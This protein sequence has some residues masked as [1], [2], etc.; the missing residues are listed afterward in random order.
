MDTDQGFQRRVTGV[1]GAMLMD[2]GFFLGAFYLASCIR[3]ATFGPSAFVLY[4]PGLIAGAVTLVFASFV[5]GLYS[6]DQLW[7]Q[8]LFRTFLLLTAI[9]AALLVVLAFGS[10]DYDA[11][12][13]RG[14]FGFGLTIL[15]PLVIL[16]HLVLSPHRQRSRESGTAIAVTEDEASLLRSLL[17]APECRVQLV[18]YFGIRSEQ[19]DELGANYAG[20]TESITNDLEAQCVLC[21]SDHLRQKH[22]GA[23]L[24]KLR[25]SGVRIATYTDL[26]EESFGAIPL[27][28]VHSNWLL[29]ATS[30]P[31]IVYVKKMKRS[32]DIGVSLI[33]GTLLL[34]VL[35]LGILLVRLTSPGPV[36]FTQSRVGRIGRPF[37]LYKLRTMAT[38]PNAK[39]ELW[40]SANDARVTP[41]GRLLRKF[42]IDEIPQFFNIL[43][44]DMSFVGPRPEQ[45]G[46]VDTLESSVPF[47][48]ERLM[49][50]P[51]LT[52][53]AQVCYP[54]GA[55]VRDARRKLEYDLY[56]L[57]HM[58]LLTDTLILL[59]TIRIVVM[60]GVPKH[61]EERIGTRGSRLDK[62][63]G[64]GHEDGT[65]SDVALDKSARPPVRA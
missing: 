14:V 23:M 2:I 51:G 58:S 50:Q 49:I 8:R 31:Q 9:C 35:L 47:Y 62:L 10:I 12:I 46:I 24:R 1:V 5:S 16:H 41:V 21:H 38:N 36:F 28:L 30:R 48:G 52:G 3:F 22:L 7:T 44:G 29:Y 59:K 13:G 42:R 43:K 19:L 60:G 20:P 56:Y 6:H 40:S 27:A 55:S 17:D 65:N 32:F 33:I 63:V 11:R 57:K 39:Q 54:Y 61:V 45:P 18:T 4:L 53:W 25:Y 37:K 34:P 26:A 64:I 15:T